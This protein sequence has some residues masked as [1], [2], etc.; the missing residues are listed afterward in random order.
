MDL[1]LTDKK[2]LVT[3]GTH[4]IGLAIV[5]ELANEGCKIAVF[6][7]TQERVVATKLMLDNVKLFV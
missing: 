6:S 4:G 1:N 3:G 2:V 7:R 5:R